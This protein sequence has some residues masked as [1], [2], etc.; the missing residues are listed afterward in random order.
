MKTL[1]TSILL[2]L[3]ISAFCQVNSRKTESLEMGIEKVSHFYPKSQNLL[4]SDFTNV[5]SQSSKSQLKSIEEDRTEIPIGDS[6]IYLTLNAGSTVKYAMMSGCYGTPKVVMAGVYAKSDT[7]VILGITP[8]VTDAYLIAIA[9]DMSIFMVYF[10]L[11]SESDMTPGTY[12]VIIMTSFYNSSSE[13]IGGY[14]RDNIKME[15][16]GPT[17]IEAKKVSNEMVKIFPNPSRFSST[18][19]FIMEKSND[20]KISVFNSH[21]QQVKIIYDGFLTSDKHEFIIDTSE[22]PSGLYYVSVKSNDFVSNKKLI[23]SK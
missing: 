6:L 9:G 11:T 13:L 8:N 10:D 12:D 1:F 16:L 23:I 3:S 21:G 7:S 22:L 2:I 19:S 17:K 20:V 5:V 14:I 18:V 4:K 15:I